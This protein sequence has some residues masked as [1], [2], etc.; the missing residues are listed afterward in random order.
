MYLQTT[1]EGG[2]EVQFLDTMILEPTYAVMDATEALVRI[3]VMLMD[4]VRV[5]QT[6]D[7][8]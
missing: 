1:L 3:S 7:E 5:G 8:M 2:V 6:I 4:R